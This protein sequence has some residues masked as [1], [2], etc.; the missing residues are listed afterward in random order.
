MPHLKQYIEI[1]DTED[2]WVDAAKDP[3]LLSFPGKETLGFTFEG[4][5]DVIVATCQAIKDPGILME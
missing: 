2:G 3:Q 4:T 5:T 1:N